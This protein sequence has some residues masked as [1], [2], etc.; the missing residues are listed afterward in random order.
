MDLDDD[1]DGVTDI[2]EFSLR[3]NPL[4]PDT[5]GDGLNDGKETEGGGREDCWL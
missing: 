3:M 5:D 4:N 2:Q 1:N